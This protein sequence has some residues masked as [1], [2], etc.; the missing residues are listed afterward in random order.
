M[1][2]TTVKYVIV[3]I[4]GLGLVFLT[5]T[6]FSAQVSGKTSTQSVPT[7]SS[8]QTAPLPSSTQAV[9]LPSTTREY[10]Q[11][12]K[13]PVKRLDVPDWD[14][15]GELRNLRF[16]YV[17][18]GPTYRKVFSGFKFRIALMNKGKLNATRHIPVKVTVLNITNNTVIKQDNHLIRNQNISNSYWNLTPEILAKFVLCSKTASKV[19]DVKLIVDIDPTN[20]FKEAQ[21]H[22]GNNR[23]VAT[24]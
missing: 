9:P 22:R 23:C 3:A 4:V 12:D 8:T 7:Q 6:A 1:M 2:R 14:L 21:R 16:H 13:P 5:G 10:Q 17:K 11:M 15:A 24:W 18:V 19:N 20:V